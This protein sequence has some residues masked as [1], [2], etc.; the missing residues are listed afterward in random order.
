MQFHLLPD[1]YPK[2]AI[3]AP[4]WTDDDEAGWALRQVAGALACVAEVHVI[5]TQGNRPRDLVDGVFCVHELATA[6]PEADL[7]RDI[8]LGAIGASLRPGSALPAD[9]DRSLTGGKG[10]D[11]VLAAS[12]RTP[13]KAGA[14]H[15]EKLAPDLVVLADYR[16]V[17]AWELVDR[18]GLDIPSLLVPL[19]RAERTT[20]LATD[21]AL[22]RRAS[23]AIVFSDGE[24]KLWAELLGPEHV[25]FVGLPFAVNA[26]VLREPEPRVGGA[27]DYILVLTDGSPARH[28]PWLE[29]LQMRFGSHR[30]VVS[31]PRT[32]A[33]R[34]PGGVGYEWQETTRPSDLLRLMAWAELTVDLHP[35]ALFGRRS[36][37]SLMYGTPIV[38][39]HDSSAQEHA[40]NGSG[41][42]WF[43]GIGGLVWCTEA[44][45]D[46]SVRA[47]LGEQG[48]RYAQRRYG[49]T[50]SFVAGVMTAVDDVFEGRAGLGSFDRDAEGITH[51]RGE[52]TC[53][54]TN[55]AS[56]ER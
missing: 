14:E 34:E 32:L 47:A 33:V 50:N 38:V 24:R 18:V 21:T 22:L 1:G 48:R 51:E 39:P 12:L 26:S 11:E 31:T 3:L 46:R 20:L 29:V 25:H 36:L 9:T 4:R 27:R 40:E 13:W 43:D 56:K 23:A 28:D 16:Q 53:S 55:S 35:G 41:G 52:R 30:V 45:L 19:A 8:V 54:P 17:G 42:L 10:I 37:E 15:L 2:V 7:R 6:N 44:I 5:T 49:S